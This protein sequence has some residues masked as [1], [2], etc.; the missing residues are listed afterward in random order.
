MKKYRVDKFFNNHHLKDYFDDRMAAMNFALAASRSTFSGPV[1]LLS[2][3]YEMAGGEIVYAT[4]EEV[5]G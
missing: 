2:N 1:F 5:K 4:I 3:P